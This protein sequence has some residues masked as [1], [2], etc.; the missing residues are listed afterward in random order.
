VERIG[1]GVAVAGTGLFALVLMGWLPVP[2]VVRDVWLYNLVWLGAVAATAARAGRDRAQRA[3]W[4]ALAVA[5]ALSAGSNVYY[6]LVLAHLDAA[7]YPSWADAGFL[8]FYPLTYFTVI[9]FLKARVERWHPSLWLDGLVLAFG[10]AAL[11]AAF[12][13]APVLQV[14]NARFAVAATDLAYPLGD[15]LLISTVLAGGWLLRGRLDTAWVLLGAGLIAMAVGDSIYLLQDSAGTYTEGTILD[16]TWLVGAVLIAGATTP[17]ATS[18]VDNAQGRQGRAPAGHRPGSP[19]TSGAGGWALLAVP[20]I[21]ATTSLGLL[22]PWGSW[23]ASAAACWLAAGALGAVGVRTVMTYR[24]VSA[25]AEARR[26]AHT[27]EL[28]GL[29]NRRGFTQRAQAHLSQHPDPVSDLVTT[30]DRTVTPAEAGVP[31]TSH[32]RTALLLLDLDRFKEVNDSLGHHAG[33]Q[34]LI[35]IAQRLAAACRGPRDLLARLGGDEFAVLLPDTDRDGAEHVAARIGA[36]LQAPFLLDDVRVQAAIS[37]GIA[38]APHHGHTLS[39][40][41]RRAD[42]AMYR[43]KATH[44]GH[45]VYDPT[46][47]DPDGEDRLQ[48]VQELRT[49]IDEDQIVVHYQPKINLATG[50]VTSVEALVRWDH[51]TSGLLY[52]DAFLALAEDAGL[53]T[54]LTATVLDQALAQAAAW[55]REGR[56]LAV[57]VNLPPAAV[58]DADLPDRIAELLTRHQ[59]PPARLKLEITEESLL[60]DRVRAR[61]VL[62]RLRLAGVRIAI[63][64]YGSGYSSLAYLR[65]LPVDELKLDRSFI[66]PMADDARAAAIVRSTVELAHSLGL[67][68][69][70]EGVEHA[71]AAN[72]LARY[73]CDGAQGFHYA[74]A[75]DPTE[76]IWWLDNR[77][78]EPQPQPSTHR[79]SGRPEVLQQLRPTD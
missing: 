75:L 20:M 9:R 40:L 4:A 73:G 45:A 78:N 54:A 3:A 35:A 69:V 68:I 30:A 63:D 25:L 72:E 36:A 37:I 79:G 58:V 28:T 14:T 17:V 51:P 46:L 62:A 23:Q 48:R 50:D 49:A 18:A 22:L 32:E 57:A 12:V 5:L 70:A 44:T 59:V 47:R 29:I 43:A 21:V 13:L 11:G 39:L 2:A 33:D 15:L 6:S 27:D 19:S 38:V 65:E 61:D 74:R 10:V 71:A 66:F 56:D 42:I 26:Q 52:P 24:E 55:Y 77:L 60:A 76:L 1:V 16:L 7:P 8:L 31:G 34:L 67:T 64:D 53:M 41:M